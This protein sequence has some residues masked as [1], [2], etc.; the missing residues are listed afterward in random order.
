VIIFAVDTV[1]LTVNISFQK[2][3]L[4]CLFFG[5]FFAT[6]GLANGTKRTFP[7]TVFTQQLEE[8]KGKKKRMWQIVRLCWQ[9]NTKKSNNKYNFINI[10]I[11][12]CQ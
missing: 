11:V 7:T 5:F 6:F 2:D 10:Q 12:D 8:K 4:G 3:W 9:K 1:H